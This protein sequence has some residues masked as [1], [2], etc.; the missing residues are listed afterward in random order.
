MFIKKN[1]YFL[2]FACIYQNNALYL[3]VDNK[4]TNNKNKAL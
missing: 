2:V 1:K 3:H 4:N